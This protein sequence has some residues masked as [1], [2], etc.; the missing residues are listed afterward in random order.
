MPHHPPWMMG[1]VVD[2]VIHDSF[3]FFE[4]RFSVCPPFRL[5]FSR[6]ET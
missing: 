3:P 6:I 5:T 2:P 4:E 1:I